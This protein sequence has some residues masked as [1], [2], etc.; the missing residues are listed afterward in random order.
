MAGNPETEVVV[1]VALKGLGTFEK[2]RKL[3]DLPKGKAEE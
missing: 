1:R 2:T 3:A